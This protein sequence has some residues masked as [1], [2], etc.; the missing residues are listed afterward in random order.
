MASGPTRRERKTFNG[1]DFEADFNRQLLPDLEMQRL[2][3]G[4]EYVYPNSAPAIKRVYNPGRFSD[5]E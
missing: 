3:Y 4:R 5:R 1:P 2:R